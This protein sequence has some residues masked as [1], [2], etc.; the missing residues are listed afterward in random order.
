MVRHTQNKIFKIIHI[1]QD[2]SRFIIIE[3]EIAQDDRSHNI[4]F[5]TFETTLTH[6]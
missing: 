4:D 3:T 1:T 2:H 5:A 6:Y